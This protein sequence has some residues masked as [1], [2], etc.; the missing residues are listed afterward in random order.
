MPP[1]IDQFMGD[2]QPPLQQQMQQSANNQAQKNDPSGAATGPYNSG[3]GI[4]FLPYSNNGLVST[5]IMPRGGL[6]EALPVLSSDPYDNINSGLYGSRQWQFDTIMTGITEGDIE[7][8]ANQP[9]TDCV[10]G[11]TGGLVKLCTMVNTISRYRGSIDPVSMYRAGLSLNRLD[12]LP[13]RLLNTV[14]A[15]Q[16]LFG[17]PDTLPEQ[18]A[19][20]MSEMSRRLF[21]LLASFRRFFSR[22]IFS[23]S[24]ANNNGE[25][26]QITGVDIHINAGNKFDAFSG[27]QCIAADSIVL[28]F[29]YDPVE[30]GGTRDIVEYLETAEYNNRINAERMGLTPIDGVLVMREGLF[31][32][33]SGAMPIKQYQEVL[34]ALEN[35]NQSTNTRIMINATDAQSQRDAMRNNFTLPLNGKMYR[36][37]LDDGITESDSTNN[38]NLAA[39]EFASDIYFVPLTVMGG[40][41]ATFFEFYQHANAQAAGILERI[42]GEVYTFV[43]DGGAFRWYIDFSKGCVELTF[44]F[45]PWLKCKFPMTGWR[46]SNVRYTPTL[47]PRDSHPDS[48]YF[49]DGGNIS[50]SSQPSVGVIYPP[51]L[52]GEAQNI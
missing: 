17:T 11:P 3:N 47:R 20:I 50:T 16:A 13:H 45:S 2:A 38:A 44:D 25:A 29:N 39:G 8:W 5:L 31:Y 19:I 6:V 22:Q 33:L 34:A 23:G 24:P 12:E 42:T 30:G 43:T 36:V 18:S 46:V 21:T 28:D 27:A 9:T 52:L 15:F 4:F 35:Q 14:P 32:Q 41:P 48:P 40:M 1:I 51:H 10:A 49:Y 37:I 26:R 7:N